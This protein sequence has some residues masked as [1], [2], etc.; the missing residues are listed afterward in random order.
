MVFT[1]VHQKL[2]KIAYF[3]KID[4]VIMN[5]ELNMNNKKLKGSKEM[6]GITKNTKIGKERKTMLN[7]ETV[8]AKNTKKWKG[9]KKMEKMQNLETVRGK[10]TKKGKERETMQNLE[11]IRDA[12]LNREDIMALCKK[13]TIVGIKHGAQKNNAGSVNLVNSGYSLP[14]MEDCINETALT[15]CGLDFATVTLE[16]GNYEEELIKCKQAIDLQF[17]GFTFIDYHI[18]EKEQKNGTKVTFATSPTKSK[19]YNS[20]GRCLNREVTRHIN[21]QKITD[22]DILYVEEYNGKKNEIVTMSYERWSK[23]LIKD[24]DLE[25]IVKDMNKLFTEQEQT[26]SDLLQYGLNQTEVAKVMK[27]SDARI[28]QIRR[29]MGTKLMNEYG[30]DIN[31]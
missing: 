18:V 6:E 29:K 28:L 3:Y 15:L 16:V 17:L 20:Y 26:V 7:L 8:K 24:E 2:I 21:N 13:I 19:I 10:N 27:L 31:F 9:S 25:I 4:Y 12:V 23:K 5:Y 14:I 30:D 11:T 22:S 1:I